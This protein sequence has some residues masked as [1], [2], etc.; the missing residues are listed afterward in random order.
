M[1]L[2]GKPG[3]ATS[4]LT[5]QGKNDQEGQ[6]SCCG[7]FNLASHLNSRFSLFA[8]A[9]TLLCLHM[10]VC[11]HVLTIVAPNSNAMRHVALQ[12]ESA[13]QTGH[14]AGPWALLEFNMLSIWKLFRLSVDS[15]NHGDDKF[16]LDPQ[17]ISSLFGYFKNEHINKSFI[18]NHIC[19][20]YRLYI[21]QTGPTG[22][23]LL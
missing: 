10:P 8:L 13:S 2:F 12:L 14:N 6:D 11:V 5:P 20:G 9:C 15:N 7:C 21:L 1:C 23:N 3:S 4:V 17:A 22:H 16:H 19:L 18:F